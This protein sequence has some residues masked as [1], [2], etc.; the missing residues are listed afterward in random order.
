MKLISLISHAANLFDIISKSAQPPD[1][2]ARD[3]FRQKKYI[4]ASERRFISESVFALLRTKLMA[5]YLSDSVNDKENIQPEFIIDSKLLVIIVMFLNFRKK[6]FMSNFNP[7]FLIR[8]LPGNNEF[9]FGSEII[10]L[11]NELYGLEFSKNILDKIISVFDMLDYDCN[12]IIN[13]SDYLS[14][15]KLAKL[16]IRYSVKSE[17]L[18]DWIAY[19][20]KNTFSIAESLFS[21]GEVCLRVDRNKASRDKVIEIL[22]KDGIL[23]HSGSLSPDSI[24]L[25]KRS[26]IV[27]H[28]LYRTGVIEIQDE[29]SQLIAYSLGAE[30]GDSILDACAGAGGK[31]LH[32]AAMLADRAA[33]VSTDIE[34]K[35]LSELGKRAARCG[36]NS[37]KPI[38]LKSGS[39]KNK[40]PREL[41]LNGFDCVLV[42]A[43]CSGMGTTRRNPMPKYRLN[44]KLL[45]RL[46]SRQSEILAN[47]S[48][49]VKPGGTLVYSTCSLMPQENIGV[50]ENFLNANPNFEPDNLYKTFSEKNIF[51]K[52]LAESDFAVTLNPAIHNCDGFFMAKLKKIY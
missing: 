6:I 14:E 27:E 28:E 13:N 1:V 18:A 19:Y 38:L 23:S 8:S 37:I 47:Y 32:L 20:G 45:A 2:I 40:L 25:D 49:Y 39:P 50:I 24:I 33:I 51:I 22:E 3:F 26:R 52:N 12:N 44:E 46:T 4:G 7:D 31:S 17:I 5:M 16:Q 21:A 48:K 42:D 10:L 30:E 9:D 35:R 29:G 36:Y 34:Y 43:P 11:L 15:E 41:K